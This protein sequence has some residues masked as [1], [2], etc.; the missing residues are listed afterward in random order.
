MLPNEG[1]WGTFSKDPQFEDQL[2]LPPPLQEAHAAKVAEV[3]R[4]GRNTLGSSCQML[5]ETVTS[6]PQ[7]GRP[8]QSPDPLGSHTPL[9]WHLRGPIL[10]QAGNWE[11][12][13]DEPDHFSDPAHRNDC[14][15]FAREETEV[16]RRE[17][18][19]PRCTARNTARLESKL[20]HFE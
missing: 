14:P 11:L 3:Q 10:S 4:M 17:V 15:L 6:V 2:G 9:S 18:T 16:H 12:N 19:C 8:F 5:W 13:I 1:T 20:I 7:P